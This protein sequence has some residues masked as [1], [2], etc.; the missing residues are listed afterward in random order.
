MLRSLNGVAV[1]RIK[2]IGIKEIL[3]AVLAVLILALLSFVPSFVKH[4]NIERQA[5]PEYKKEG[6]SAPIS[7]IENKSGTVR[8][9]SSEGKELLYGYDHFEYESSGYNNRFRVEQPV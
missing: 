5:L 4:W 9:A 3:I 7:K 1:K 2:N 8:L 6:L